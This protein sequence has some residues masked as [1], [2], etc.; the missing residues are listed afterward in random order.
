[1]LNGLCNKILLILIVWVGLFS[2]SSAGLRYLEKS[3]PSH[4]SFDTGLP[5]TWNASDDD[6]IEVNLGFTF[7]FNNTNYTKIWINS[8]GML[9]FN[10]GITEYNNQSLPRDNVKQSIYPYWDD[11]DLSADTDTAE[12]TYGKVTSGGERFVVYWNNV[13]HYNDNSKKYTFQI[14]LYSD[15][16]IR[17]R[18][19]SSSNADGSSATVG[20]QEDDDHYE[21]HSKN[22]DID[23]DETKDILYT[24]VPPPT[25]DD[26][27]DFHFDEL[28]W[29]GT[30]GEVKDSHW[31]KDGEGYDVVSVAGK[32]CQA[33]DLRKNSDSDY[34][35]LDVNAIYELSDF[36]AS[37]WIATDQSTDASILTGSKGSED[38]FQLWMH[39]DKLQ[40]W[41]NNN[42]KPNV[43]LP[44]N[45][46]NNQWHHVV[47]RRENGNMCVFFDGSKTCPSHTTDIKEISTD[48]FYLG[49]ETDNASTSTFSSNQDYE[50]LID[51]LMI[52]RKALTDSEIQ[53]GYN[54]QNAGKNWDGTDRICP[55]PDIIKNSCVT[56]DPVNGTSN[57]KRIPGATI[58]YTVEIRNPNST[59]M[60]ETKVKDDLNS[61]F[62]EAS[63]TTPKVVDNSCDD[64]LSLTGGSTGSS[65]VT[66]NKVE[67]D[68]GDVTGGTISSPTKECGYFEVDIK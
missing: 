27:S 55:Y 54:N 13:P 46:K 17:F 36:T 24:P 29:D 44:S 15:G 56:N 32:I 9:S 6:K 52:F 5:N 61:K 58:R 1:M 45:F 67:I 41:L 43:T 20:M 57:P 35:E 49:Q 31:D 59:T 66:S 25:S 14:I 63:I 39:G 48:V 23:L 64:C 33:M 4:T 18:Y 19:D 16:S 42:T 11:L 51:E 37:L 38:I 12:I 30:K 60:E 8:N 50:G 26:Y 21:Q 68:F 2:Y 47:W 22:S 3:I 62:V 7:S 65:S 28:G 10:K 34:S 40:L 53:T